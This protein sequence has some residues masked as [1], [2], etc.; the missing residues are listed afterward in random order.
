[1]AP[2]SQALFAPAAVGGPR[3]AAVAVDPAQGAGSAA[4]WEGA[5]KGL[6]VSINLLPEDI[7]ARRA[8]TN[9]CSTRS[10]P[11]G[12]DPKGITVEITESA[13]LADRGGGR[14]ARSFAR[15]PAYGSRSTISAPASEPR[16]SDLAAAR[17]AQDQPRTDRRHRRRQARP[18]RGQGNDRMARESTS[19]WSSKGREAPPS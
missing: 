17:H 16:L 2:R 3:R 7:S 10:R 8:T 4:K 5:L 14:A 1:M 15:A 18:D 11:A 6:S 9:G 12:I 19:R 13:L